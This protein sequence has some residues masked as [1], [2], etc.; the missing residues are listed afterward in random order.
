MIPSEPKPTFGVAPNPT[1]EHTAQPKPSKPSLPSLHR[2]DTGTAGRRGPQ[3]Q[4]IVDWATAF[5][6][7]LGLPAALINKLN[8]NLRGYTDS[9][10]ALT[11]G[12][13]IL[14]QSDWFAH[15]YPGFDVGV[16]HGLYTDEQGYRDYVNRLNVL[17]NEYQ[18]RA[19]TS[20]EVANYLTAGY[21]PGTV[22][23]IL[24]G[25]ATAQAEAPQ[26]QA[27]AGA[28]GTGPLSQ[29][30]LQALGQQQAGFSTALGLRVQQMVDQAQKRM[31]GVFSSPNLATPALT[32]RE[33][34][35][36][37]RA[38]AGGTTPNPDVGAL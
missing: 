18:N 26:V 10:T 21:D 13:N 23:N 2:T 20:N 8:E 38:L 15:N 1:S 7:S 4:P 12:Q 14:R 28:F 31:Q 22:G 5:W 30:Q 29:K 27:A 24:Q 34:N 16:Q 9:T 35:A 32:A 6:G 19:I 37:V 33:M 36:G 25:N 17:S 3:G 11:V